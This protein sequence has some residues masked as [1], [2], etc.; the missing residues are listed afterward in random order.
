[1]VAKTLPKLPT[2]SLTGGNVK[3]GSSSWILTCKNIREALEEYGCFAAT[4]DGVSMDLHNKVFEVIKPMF[5]LPMEV[6]T[7][8]T[9]NIPY[10]GYYRPGPILPLLDSFGIDDAT[11]LEKTRNFTHLLWPHG[12]QN[13]W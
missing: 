11:A 3:P 7:K 13:L 2:V 12:N 5:E 6:K 9:S 4:Y 8:N 1:M 10:H